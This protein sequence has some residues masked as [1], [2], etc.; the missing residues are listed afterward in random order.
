MDVRPLAKAPERKASR[1]DL[2]R[3]KGR[4]HAGLNRSSDEA[5]STGRDA[6]NQRASFEFLRIEFRQNG[7]V[8]IANP[9]GMKATEFKLVDS[10]A[11]SA[12]FEHSRH[13]KHCTGVN[14]NPHPARLR[15]DYKVCAGWGSQ[16]VIFDWKLGAGWGTRLAEI[17][18]GTSNTILLGE[19]QGQVSNGTRLLAS[20]WTRSPSL[21]INW[22]VD[23]E[24]N[25]V[26][27]SPY[28]NPFLDVDGTTRYSLFQFST[29]HPGVVMFAFCDGSTIP[30]D[31]N[32]DGE[33]MNAIST[34]G[35]GE[36]FN[37]DD[38]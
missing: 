1:R 10:D 23:S 7:V 19:T 6:T 4:Y 36:I 5:L 18:D 32:T 13:D 21:L 9:G 38:L 8:Y 31:R 26:I 28:L 29:A 24:S 16:N 34:R 15:L 37:R 14:G 22:A 35:E 12:R 2:D 17:Y 27:P 3:P 25:F 33:V 20:P 30:V 11:T